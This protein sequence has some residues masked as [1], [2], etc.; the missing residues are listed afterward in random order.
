[1]HAYT[2]TVATSVQQQWFSL[3]ESFRQ[4]ARTLMTNRLRAG[5]GALAIAVA[6]GT[7]VLVVTALDGVAAFANI[8]TSRAFG[9]ETFLLAQVASP[10]R[11]SRRELQD[12][13]QRNQ[14]IRRADWR[15]LDASAGDLVQY[16]PI[17]QTT[18]EVT[19]GSRTYETAAVSG[20]TSVLAG[21]R[22]LAIARGRFLSLDDDRAGAVVS[23]IGADVADTLFPASDAVGQSIRVAGRRFTVIG[24]QT[25]LGTSGGTSLDRSVWIPI[26]AWERAFGLPRSLP[27]F[28]KATP[29]ATAVAA[30][31]RARAALRAR[32]QLPPGSPDTFD[33][34]TPDAA[35][36][37]VANLSQRIGIAAGP[38][39]LM[40]LL[41]A[42]VVVT[43]TVLVSVTQRTREIGVRRALGAPRSQ[44]MREVVAESALTAVIGGVVGLAV[45]LGLVTAAAGVLELPLDVRASTAGWSLVASAASG[46]VAGWYPARRATQLTVVEA[47]RVE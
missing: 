19:A 6:V 35:R 47:I 28:A 31:D 37:F 30:E 46:L 2:H 43:N 42:I 24:V 12:Q 7:Q 1:M 23:V 13:L 20:T 10:G 40:A 25:K 11:V 45:A 38:I 32:R 5:L 44:I 27:I 36:G 8:S 26:R 18:A 15:F 3:H 17:V 22:D 14:P 4:A 33:V 9:S 41:A 29:G 39:S 34:L 21:L 16:A